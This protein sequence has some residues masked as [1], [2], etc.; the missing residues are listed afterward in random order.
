MRI[1]IKMI[2][3]TLLAGFVLNIVNCN[4]V[5]SYVHGGGGGYKSYGGGRYRGMHGNWGR[6]YPGRRF[7]FNHRGRRYFY[8]NGWFFDGWFFEEEGFEFAIVVPPIGTI[9]PV[10]PFGFETLMFGPGIVYYYVDGVYYKAVPEGY[11]VVPKSEVE[12][13]EQP[14]PVAPA[15]P[16]GKNVSGE[17]YVINIPNSD[18]SFTPIKLKKSDNGYIGPQGE[19]YQG[20]PSIEQLKVLYGK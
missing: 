12:K 16:T 9:V 14:A 3:F 5:A 20:H 6:S 1:N 19:F 7:S 17:E 15:A 11:V 18:G 10:L 8:H 13:Y 2:L 4:V